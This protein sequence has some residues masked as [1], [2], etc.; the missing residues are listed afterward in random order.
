[1]LCS[2]SRVIAEVFHLDPCP[3]KR[4]LKKYSFG[5]TG[6]IRY[7]LSLCEALIKTFYAGLGQMIFPKV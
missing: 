7:I 6:S 1:L 3:I 5:R 2:F 4:Y